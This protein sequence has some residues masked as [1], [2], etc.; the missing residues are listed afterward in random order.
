MT[1]SRDESVSVP[2][3]SL[4]L[5]RY[6]RKLTTPNGASKHQRVPTP[7]TFTP[8]TGCE[9]SGFLVSLH[10]QVFRRGFLPPPPAAARDSAE[11]PAAHLQGQHGK[12]LENV[13]QLV[14]SYRRETP[15]GSS[16]RHRGFW[17]IP[18]NASR[19][20]S[21]CPGTVLVEA[22]TFGGRR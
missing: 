8:W 11:I 21:L 19:R 15:P 4:F 16:Y 2:R 9:R 7:P 1:R 10:L 14:S 17:V 18:R 5:R 3:S 20:L 12:D 13:S 6:S 22:E